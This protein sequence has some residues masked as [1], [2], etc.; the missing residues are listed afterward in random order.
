VVEIDT[1]ELTG[2]EKA[3][4][5]VKKGVPIR[6]EV[7]SKEIAANSVYMGRRDKE[8]KDRKAVS[9]QEFLDT[10]TAQLDEMQSYLLNRARDFQ[11]QNLVLINN[12]EDFYKYFEGDG[13]FALA[14]W[15]GSTEVEAKIKTDLSVT[16]RCIPLQDMGDG[17]GKC[18]FT[19]E[20]SKQRVIFA[21]A[22]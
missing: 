12:K 5:W 20:P 8:Y 11:K 9:R 22:Y 19:G 6:L 3:W 7:G 18:I 16:T 13:G 1:R 10:I 14:H 15:N 4:S 2:G 21:K 17:A